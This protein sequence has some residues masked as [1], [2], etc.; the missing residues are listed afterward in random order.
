[1]SIDELVRAAAERLD[2]RG[3]KNGETWFVNVPVKKGG[4]DEDERTQMVTID[5]GRDPRYLSVATDV[6]VLLPTI[7]LVAILEAFGQA[8]HARALLRREGASRTQAVAASARR[9]GLDPASLAEI[10]AEV[11]R[12]ADQIEARHFSHAVGLSTARARQTMRQLRRTIDCDYMGP[13]VAAAFLRVAGDEV[14]FIETNTNHAVPRLLAALAGEGL[15][16][17]SVRYIVVTH[18][19][20]DHAGGAGALAAACPQATVLAHPRAARHLRDPSK[21][22]KGAS[23]VYGAERFERLYGEIR[24]IAPERVRELADGEAVP[25]GNSELRALHTRGHAKHHMIVHDPALDAVFTGDAFGLA[26]PQLQRAGTFAFPST[27]PTDFEADEAH[28]SVDRVLSLGVSVACLTHFG[29]VTDLA[30]VASQLHAW[31][32]LSEQL[33]AS[34]RGSG[35]EA[36]VQLEA[37]LRA[38]M[39]ERATAQGLSLTEQDWA[40]LE[41]DLGLNA[42]GLWVA[43]QA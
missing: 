17:E 29:D 15:G 11:A 23:Q 32:D 26:Y 27:S 13:G 20:L 43:A 4:P 40:L 3:D 31:I 5:A 8:T 38:A 36:I 22:I 39:D 18:V 10:V 34:A 35:S 9:E 6:G 16:P 30:T 7:D 37:S 42:Q 24:P 33:R 19:H 28:R 1:M 21:L 25:F 2:A 12:T 41:L 14:A